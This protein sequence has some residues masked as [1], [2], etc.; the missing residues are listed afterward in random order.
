MKKLEE[1]DVSPAPWSSRRGFIKSDDADGIGHFY[2]S[3]PGDARLAAA[4]PELY[5]LVRE[6]YVGG[7]DALEWNDRAKAALEKAGGAE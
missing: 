6:M 2:D 1:L 7:V 4:A 5:E 3:M